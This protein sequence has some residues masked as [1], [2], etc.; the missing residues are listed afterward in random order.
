MIPKRAFINSVVAASAFAVAGAFGAARADYPEKPIEFIIP[1]GAGGGADIEGRLLATEMSRIL[2]VNL[3][4]INKVG[5]GGAV[6]YTYLKNAAPDGY[7]VAWNS[8]S[9]LTT[10]NLGNVDY[11]YDAMDHVG[12]V[13]WQP[14]PFAVSGD[15]RWDTFDEFVAECRDNPRSLKV[16]NSGSGSATHLAAIALM[17][18][19]GCEV[20]H[21]P[22]GIKRRNASVLSGEADAMIAPLTGAVNLTKAGKLKLLA[23]PSGSRNSVMPDV[24]TARELG[25]DIALDLFRGLSVPKGTPEDVKARLAEAMAQ[26]ARSEKFMDLAAQKGF[27]VDPLDSAAFDELLAADNETIETILK[28]A[29]LSG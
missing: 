8:T 12:R 14:M 3:I 27:T 11:A 19:A 23:M 16:S 10:T 24:P 4:P 29:D 28:N 6:A 2:G 25:Y 21:L 15:A 20:T 18:A 7:T 1:F 17:D 9:I 5:G 22:V 13:E 26:A